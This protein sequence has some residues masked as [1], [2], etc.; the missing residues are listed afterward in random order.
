[1]TNSQ[2]QP[3]TQNP[4]GLGQIYLKH[5]ISSRSSKF[6]PNLKTTTP[7]F[8]VH[9]KVRSCFERVSYENVLPAKVIVLLQCQIYNC[10]NEHGIIRQYQVGTDSNP[11]LLQK[12]I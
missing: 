3:S 9:T 6:V 11:A 12:Q 8:F 4:R 10:N 2:N 7:Y 5:L 1:M